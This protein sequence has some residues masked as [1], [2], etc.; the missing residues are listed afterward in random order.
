GPS[1]G[2]G[3]QAYSAAKAAVINLPR[4]VAIELAPAHIRV[5]CICP[6]GINTPLIHRGSPEAMGQPLDRAQPWPEHGRPEGIAR[7]GP[8]AAGEAGRFVTGAALLV[9]GRLTCV[10]GNTLR[11]QAGGAMA[12]QV[13]GLD[14]GSTGEPST[15]RGL[16]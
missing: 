14:R 4:A 8:D 16:R 15:I 5:N 12:M 7:A 13:V 11:G 9:D 10:G 2:H 1:G 6:G 3:P